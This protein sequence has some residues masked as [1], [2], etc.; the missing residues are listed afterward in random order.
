MNKQALECKFYGLVQGV[1]FRPFVHRL[2]KKYDIKGWVQNSS[3]GLT[4]LAE[5]TDCNLT[6]FTEKLLSSHPLQ[7]SIAKYEITTLKTCGYQDFSI[8]TS[9]TNCAVSTVIAPDTGICETCLEE[10]YDRENIREGYLLISCAECGPRFSITAAYPYDRK[11]TAMQSFTMCSACQREYED[12]ESR[13]YHTEAIACKVCGPRVWLTDRNGKEIKASVHELLKLGQIVAVKGI[14]GF[15]L[16]VDALNLAAVVRLRQ[17]KKRDSK[18]FA[19]MCRDVKTVQ[20]YCKVSRLEEKLLKSPASP[21]V[22]LERTELELPLVI[23]PGLTTLGVM[24][25]YTA[26]HR[27]LF[28]DKLEMVVLTSANECDEPII[29]DNK[30][31]IIKLSGIADSFLLN[32]R[33]IINSC[34]DSVAAVVNKEA[35]VYRRSRGYV[36]LPISINSEGA[37]VLAAGGD[38]KNT[39]CLLGDNEAYLSQHFGDLVYYRN[40]QRYIEGIK[41]FK[42]MIACTP[43]VV[44][45]DLHPDF[46]SAMYAKNLGHKSVAVQHHHAHLASCMAENQLDGQ[47]LGVILDGSGYGTDGCIWGFEFLYGGYKNFERLA[48]LE[49]VPMAGGS[50]THYQ[51]GRTAACYL[52]SLFQDIGLSKAKHL[53]ADTDIE[54]VRRQ[55]SS[56]LGVIKTSSCGRLFDAAAALT[57]VCSKVHYEGKAAMLFEAVS[58]LSHEKYSFKLSGSKYPYT[59]SVAELFEEMLFDIKHGQSKAVI[60]GRFHAVIIDMA[61]STIWRLSYEKKCRDVVLSGGCFQNRLLLTGIMREL[62]NSGLS[63]YIQRKV[64]TNDGGISLG[65]AVVA[66]EVVKH[67]SGCSGESHRD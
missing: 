47:V 50:Q 24:L 43:K 10:F 48:H 37:C 46:I 38:L 4:I 9:E 17:H 56:G 29:C 57:G 61:V 45:H 64:P 11:N 22:L 28:D 8:R 65:Q 63:V 20:K 30:T 14:G 23:S 6:K 40:F 15:H 36:P 52:Y 32:D 60:G 3:Q 58:S 19:V 1:G 55:L 49:Y 41:C 7:A 54:G 42:E 16:A 12:I 53:L 27:T 13:R 66:R 25:P 31:A 18:P 21:I 26:L 5:G 51:A 33:E 44:A 39:F 2:A 35:M 67:V 34:D 62:K 59:L